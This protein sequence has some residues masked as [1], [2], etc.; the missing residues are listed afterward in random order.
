MLTQARLGDS[1]L[2][3]DLNSDGIPDLAVAS[4]FAHGTDPSSP[5]SGKVE[6]FFLDRA[7]WGG[8]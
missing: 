8:K 5:M 1:I 2:V 7:H 4:P 3:K 6:V